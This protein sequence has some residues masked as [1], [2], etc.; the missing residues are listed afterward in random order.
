M[1]LGDII[2]QMGQYGNDDVTVRQLVCE[3]D[4][5]CDILEARAL[6]SKDDKDFD[7]WDEAERVWFVAH[8]EDRYHVDWGS[9]VTGTP[10]NS[11][12]YFSKIKQ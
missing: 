7:N 2:N 3:A 5:T 9:H 8:C 11:D 12:A 10:I 6:A 4:E 1:T